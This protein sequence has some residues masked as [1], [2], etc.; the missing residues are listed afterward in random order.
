MYMYVNILICTTAEEN[1][2]KSKFKYFSVPNI[3]GYEQ[4]LSE[5]VKHY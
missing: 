1:I 3:I 4:F 2:V 5:N